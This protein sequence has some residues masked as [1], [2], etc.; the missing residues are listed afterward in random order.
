MEAPRLA[1]HA[2]RHWHDDEVTVDVYVPNHLADGVQHLMRTA[3][4]ERGLGIVI[5]D[6]ARALWHVEIHVLHD[7]YGAIAF[8]VLQRN[9]GDA[10]RRHGDGPVGAAVSVVE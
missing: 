5:L 7:G 6:L 4:L 8:V 10:V 9:R 1:I 3:S 2:G